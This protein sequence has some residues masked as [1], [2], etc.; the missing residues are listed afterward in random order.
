MNKILIIDDDPSDLKGMA[1]V[2]QKQGYA[3][4]ATAESAQQGLTAVKAMNPDFVIMDVVL[5]QIDGLDIAKQIKSQGLK[6]KVIMVTGH[7]DAVNAAKAR[8]SGAD[9]II[10]KTQGFTSLVPTLKRLST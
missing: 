2:L 7:L 8:T 4:V 5:N 3:D 1:I 6:T 9:E 10:E